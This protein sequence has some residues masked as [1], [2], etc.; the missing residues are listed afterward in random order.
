MRAAD[1]R[2]GGSADRA[3]G[4]P[5][6]PRTDLPTAGRLL[7]VDWGEKRI[8]LAVCDPSQ[9]LAQPLAT[10]TRRAGRR[11]PMR[12]L[13]RHLDELQPAGVVIGLPLSPD[14]SENERTAA[15]R[16]VGALVAAQTGLPVAY[17]DERLTTARALSAVRELGARTRGRPGDVDRLA[18][19]VLLQA[20][21]D[22]RRR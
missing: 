14:G 10:L 18:A 16:A 5:A 17:A 3:G 6:S 20:F 1:R 4:D 8:G 21:L 19:T 2:I 15:A 12:R 22:G 13:R 11:F 7:G 9:V